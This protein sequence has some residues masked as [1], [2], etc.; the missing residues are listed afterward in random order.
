MD[1]ILVTSSPLFISNINTIGKDLI[2]GSGVDPSGVGAYEDGCADKW[3]GMLDD[4]QI[5]DYALSQSEIQ[6]YMTCPPTGN[7]QGLVGY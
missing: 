4:V 2:I 5:W 3:V 1:G 6:Q 7:E